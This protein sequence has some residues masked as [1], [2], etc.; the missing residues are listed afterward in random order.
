MIGLSSK[1]YYIFAV[2]LP[3]NNCIN[4]YREQLNII[5]ATY[6]Y[7]SEIGH[8]ILGGDWNASLLDQEHINVSKSMELRQFVRI[9]NIHPINNMVTCTGP[10]YTYLPMKSMIDYIFSDE[11]TANLVLSCYIIE[12]GSCSSTSDHLPIV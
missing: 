2:Y 6:T 3:S 9:N 8:V 11:V 1:P 5:Q 10:R 4:E 12:E 7:Y